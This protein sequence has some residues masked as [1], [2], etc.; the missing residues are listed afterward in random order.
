M[1][2]SAML[3]A[4]CQPA[5]TEPDRPDPEQLAQLA[6]QAVQIAG[7]FIATL[8]PTLQQ[9]M[10]AGGPVNGI[11]VCALA[12][13]AIAASLSETSGWQV[14][15]VSLLARN[16]QSAVPDEWE[17][18]VLHEFDSRQ[19]TGEAAEQINQSGFVDGEF[20]Y[21]QAQAVGPLC[22]VCHGTEIAPEV[23]DALQVHYPDDAATGYLVGQIRGAISLRTRP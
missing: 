3:L 12:A 18:S 20:R 15:R 13:P 22:L 6:E 14:R 23:Q 4:A 8:Q 19:A 9:A 7:Q 17:T 1:A 11:E 10:Q 16:S 21:M 5:G 2:V